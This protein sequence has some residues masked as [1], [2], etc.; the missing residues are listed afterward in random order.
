MFTYTVCWYGGLSSKG[1]H[2]CLLVTLL[3]GPMMNCLQL[4]SL[5]GDG[6]GGHCL[7]ICGLTDA[8]GVGRSGFLVTG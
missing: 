1:V 3:Y 5:H 4:L 7:L 6:P 8:G 2:Y